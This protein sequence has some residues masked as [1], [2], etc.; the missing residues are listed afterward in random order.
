MRQLEDMLRHPPTGLRRASEEKFRALVSSSSWTSIG[1]R[2]E[3]NFINFYGVSSGRVTALALDPTNQNVAYAGGADGGVWKTSDGGVNWTPLTDFQP[4]LSIGSLAIDPSNPN[5]IYAGTGEANWNGDGYLGDGILRSTDGGVS[6]TAIEGPFAGQSMG[7]IAVSPTD[8]KVLLAAASSGIYRSADRGSTWVRALPT[9]VNTVAFESADGT[10]AYAGTFF[11]GVYKSIDGGVTWKLLTLPGLNPTVFGRV[12]L[13]VAPGHP[14]VL[15]AGVALGSG[16]L[17]GFFKSTDGGATWKSGSTGYCSSQCIYNNAI[18]VSPI[19]PNILV[20][21]GTGAFL[22]TD[23]GTSWVQLRT[24]AGDSMHPDQ[25]AVAFSADGRRLWMGNDGGV[26]ASTSYLETTTH[27]E[28]LNNTLALAQFYQGMAV[29]PTDINITLGGTQDNGVIRYSG[30]PMWDIVVAPWGDGASIQIDPTHP[31]IVYASYTGMLLTK[32][33]DGGKTFAAA[34]GGLDSGEGAAANSQLA[35]DPSNPARL[36]LGGNRKLWETTNGAA[37]W[38]PASPN[39]GSKPLCVVAVSPTDVNKVF[40]GSCGTGEIYVTTNATAGTSSAWKV[41]SINGGGAISR[42]AMD[43]RNTDVVYVSFYGANVG[44]VWKSVDG[45]NSFTNASGN[46]PAIPCSDLEIDPDVPD[47]IYLATDVGVFWTTNGGG[48]WSPLV[49]GL[50][51]VAV[52]SVRL[53]R[54]TRTLRVATHGRGMWDLQVPVEGLNLIP[55]LLS[56]DPPGVPAGSPP[57][58]IGVTGSNFVSGTA[59][60]WNG[61][62]RPTTVTSSTRLSFRLTAD[63]VLVA[64]AGVISVVN[65]APGGGTS[66]AVVY[67][68]VDPGTLTP[69]AGA[70]T[71]VIAYWPADNSPVDVISRRSAQLVNGAAFANGRVNQ[72]FSLNGSNSYVQA[73]GSTSA[74]GAR[75][76]AARV[77]PNGGGLGMPILTGGSSGAG[78]FFGITGIL[79]IGNCNLLG[80]YRLYVDHWGTSCLASNNTVKTGAWSHVAVT[81]DGAT[82]QFYINGVPSQKVEGSMYDYPV[83]TYAIGGN[84]IGGSTTGE[85]FKGLLDEVQVYDRALSAAEI[86]NLIDMAGPTPS[87]PAITNVANAA[88]GQSGVV[89]GSFIS[90]YGSNFTTLAYDDWSKSI[91]GGQLPQQLDGVTVKI[92]GKPAYVNAITPGQIN[93]QAP[94]LNIQQ[95]SVQV[96]VTTAAGASQALSTSLREVDPAFFLWPGNQPVA[97]H[98]D[99]SYAIRDGSFAGLSTTPAKPGEVIILWGTGFGPTVPPV[100]AGQIPG[101]SSGAPTQYPVTV[102]LD[103]TAITVYGTA[104]SAFPAAYQTAIQIPETISDGDHELIVS[105]NGISSPKT[106]LN[107]QR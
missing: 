95:Q 64:S 78:D 43:P 106:L 76:L 5:N 58:A 107:V 67:R 53:H 27:W 6:W 86:Q 72:A 98:S 83:N 30:K 68:V 44:H 57:L 24:E 36:Y 29:H 1:P 21:G 35:M 9:L 94:D 28:Q 84:T 52:T 93:V 89:P 87:L 42:I 105:I 59:V 101:A 22:S 66:R 15:Y 54:P 73:S 71:G 18:A 79:G 7:G 14:G 97:T 80:Q 17:Q 56:F 92:G 40:A 82:I 103:G 50:P 47:T 23:G 55:Q 26:F 11:S 62:L 77:Y 48:T 31:N 102:T 32:S 85:S 10:T 37:S 8:G 13:A 33:V 69:P 19:D 63:D 3:Q 61:S 49:S 74:S 46:L 38:H 4:T 12:A 16:G 100:P 81:Y 91:A 45:G 70:L 34:T 75:T 2:P 39:L 41:V 51:R 90:I 99:Y 88:G 96:T 20:G 60:L 25:H 104:L 65:P